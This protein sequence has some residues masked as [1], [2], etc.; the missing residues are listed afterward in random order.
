MLQNKNAV[1]TGAARGIGK[2]LVEE[3]AKNGANVWAC[4]RKPSA[5]FEAHLQSLA[6]EFGVWVKPL[7]FDMRDAA[8]MKEA[9]KAIRAEKLPVD[10]LVNCAGV[11]HGGLFQMTPVAQI[12]DVF[13]VNFFAQLE[14]TQLILKIMLRQKSGAIL[15]FSSI[16]GLDL[17]VGN[18]AY[19]V[20]KAAIAAWTKTIG[21][22]LAP[23]GIRVNA[24][25]PALVQTDMAHLME[26]KA[27]EDLI[28][29]SAMKRLARPQEIAEL[30]LF[31]V[32]DKASFLN[33]QTIRIDGGGGVAY[34]PHK[35]A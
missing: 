7:Y 32:S 25:A 19:G 16:A 22:E 30:A 5:E 35:K 18:C 6:K 10:I 20:S 27:A 4:A 15:N 8:A 12:K 33:G 21:S 3:F 14:L 31:L 1:V 24:V 13:E 28:E 26:E 34:F 11:A 29:S 9:V 17:K 23:Y 2:V